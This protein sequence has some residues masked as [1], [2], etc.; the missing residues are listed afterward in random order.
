MAGEVQYK[1]LYDQPIKEDNRIKLCVLRPVK[2][3]PYCTI[4]E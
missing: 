2:E 3:R 4:E 1:K